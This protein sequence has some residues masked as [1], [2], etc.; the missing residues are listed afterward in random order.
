MVFSKYVNAGVDSIPVVVL[1]WCFGLFLYRKNI[2]TFFFNFLV[3]NKLANLA[4]SQFTCQCFPLQYLN[5]L[6][7]LRGDK[8][9]F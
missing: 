8:T 3:E 1:G 2:K 9:L 7:T 6:Y 4:L 5:W